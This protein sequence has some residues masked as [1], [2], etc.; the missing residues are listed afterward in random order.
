MGSNVNGDIKVKLES[1]AENNQHLSSLL[2]QPVTTTPVVGVSNSVS[3]SSTATSLSQLPVSSANTPITPV[4]PRS[5]SIKMEMDASVKEEMKTEVKTEPSD[6]DPSSQIKQESTSESVSPRI[7]S[8]DEN[9]QSNN[10]CDI[11]PFSQQ[12]KT[13]GNKKGRNSLCVILFCFLMTVCYKFIHKRFSFV[14][15]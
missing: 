8:M 3:I 6:D 4:T 11:K 5:N 15:F 14:V 10:S 13:I 12:P 2:S 1:V 7:E 9:S